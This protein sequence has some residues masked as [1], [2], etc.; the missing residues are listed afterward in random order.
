MKLLLVKTSSMGDVIHTFPAVTDALAHRPDLVIDWAVEPAFAPLV[1]LHPGVRRIWP[2]AIRTW[3]KTL[4]KPQTRR[5]IGAL[6]RDLQAEG[7]DRVLDAQGLVKSA[8]LAR[9][10]GAPVDGFDRTSVRE[11]LA[12][13]AYRR[14]HPVARDLHAVD[15]TRLLLGQTLGYQPDLDRLSTGIERPGAGSRRAVLLHGTTWPSKRWP[16]PMWIALARAIADGGWRP[17]LTF[18][19]ADEEAVARAIADAVPGAILVPRRPLGE[20][21]EWIAGAGLAVGVDTGLTHL[22]AALGIPTVALFFS[23]RPGLTGP[24]GRAASALT[25]PLPCAPCLKR[26]CPLVPAGGLPPCH[27][28]IGPDQILTEIAR[29][30]R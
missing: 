12:T 23:T 9:L 4:L 1:R 30:T 11:P 16:T 7:Y 20:V 5:E 10:A 15:R 27:A 13:L 25:A 18:S 17:E 28:T 24:R 6:R 14:R 8:V 29:L 3:R 26:E 2:A 22:S 21:A 19:D